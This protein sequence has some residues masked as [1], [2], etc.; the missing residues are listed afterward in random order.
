[1]LH[2]CC[3]N[4]DIVFLQYFG[5]DKK[6]AI[7][8]QEVAIAAEGWEDGMEVTGENLSNHKKRPWAYGWH[9]A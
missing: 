9:P 4:A 3:K 5:A 8:L 7:D 2:F 1:M 6:D